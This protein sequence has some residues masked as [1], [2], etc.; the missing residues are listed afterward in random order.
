MITPNEPGVN[1][2]LDAAKQ[3]GL[4]VIALDT[5]PDP[6][7]TVDI[8]FATDVFKAGELIGKWT[9]AQLNGKTANIERCSTS[10]TT[11]SS[12]STTTVTRGSSPGWGSTSRTRR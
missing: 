8:T 4:Y 10:S 11:G 5:P 12:R 3:A 1:S 9:A 7:D 6:A 2:A